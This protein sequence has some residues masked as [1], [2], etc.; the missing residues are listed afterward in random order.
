MKELKTAVNIF[1]LAIDN[2]KRGNYQLA[3][4][5][6]NKSLA[7]KE[8]WQSYQGLGWALYN[9]NQ[10]DPAI[11]AF[12][13]SL[14]LKE[15]WQSYQGLGLALYNTNQY[16]PA[17]EAFNKSLALKEGWQSYQ[18]LG[19]ALYNTNQ[20]DPAIEAFNKSLALKEGWQ[21]YQGLGWALYNTN[22]YDPAIEAFNKSLALKESWQS[23][24]GL[25]LA[26]NKLG[27]VKEATRATQNYYRHSHCNPHKKIDPFLGEKSG[28]AVTRDLIEGITKNLS[29]IQF[30]F[31][32]SYYPGEQIE[33]QLQ[34]WK[35]LIYIHI[36][37]CA[38]TTF[39]APLSKLLKYIELKNQVGIRNSNA[40]SKHY[41]WHG[42]LG[43][44]HNHDAYLLEAF[45][46]KTFNDL[47]GSF[48]ANHWARHGTYYQRLEKEGISAKKI[49]LVRDPSQRLYSHIREYTC[50][51]INKH[52]LLDMCIEDLSNI[53]DRYIYDY[54][55]FKGYEE[56]PYCD[57][58]D[59]EKCETIDFL[60]ISDN[61]AI[62]KVKSS[63]LS[64][65]L[66]PNIVQYNRLN[67][68]KNKIISK[69]SLQDE[70]FQSIHKEL[71]SR[72]YLERDN[73]IDLEFLKQRTKE[74][75]NFPE[76][77]KTGTVL[78]PI[79]FIYS[80]FGATKLI[81]TKDFIADPLGA[82][83]CKN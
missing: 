20:Y 10:Y 46:G 52:V 6:F 21:S 59:Y 61:H 67:D 31:Y 51:T 79:T 75:L 36:D 42:N 82:I 55:L 71:I 47:Q 28:V 66:L 40:E 68:D 69:G 3:I 78:H 77:I 54:N 26:L 22:Q 24:Q 2:Y 7:L 18:G 53:M 15:G 50:Y 70:D 4:K 39:E 41:L 58:F 60:D 81:R 45:K 57:P 43:E 48:F 34:S 74:R 19:W 13:K 11:E 37:K 14:A 64:A 56:S 32:P 16:D 25:G 62:S 72:G 83:N 30:E 76:L 8:G 63:F 33:E 9:T 73:Q 5:A 65:T 35:H 27:K 38:G 12:N 29:R 1:A 80:K 17:I 44:K 23:Y 49:C